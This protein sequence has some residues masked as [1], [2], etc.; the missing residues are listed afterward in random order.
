MLGRI[1]KYFKMYPL[2]MIVNLFALMLFLLMAAIVLDKNVSFAWDER[3]RSMINTIRTSQLDSWVEFFT[4]L[5]GAAG[6]ASFSLIILSI[7]IYHKWFRDIQFYIISV[8]GASI[9]FVLIKYSVQRIR[10]SLE[11]VDI[12]GYSFPSAH[13]TVATATSLAVYFIF[14]KKVKYETLQILLAFICLVWPL[15]IAAS[16]VYLDVHWLSDV[17]AGLL[18]GLFW[19]TLLEIVYPHAD[20]RVNEES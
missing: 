2:L 12:G 3:I 13:T 5:N 11:I 7:L 10:P 16:R 8:I 9:V 15:M 1:L 19:V 18:L 4:D 14:V 20:T 6:V 17:V